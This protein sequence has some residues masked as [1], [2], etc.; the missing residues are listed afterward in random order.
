[1]S[2]EP[3]LTG[4]AGRIGTITLNRPARRNAVNTPMRDALHQQIRAMADNAEVSVILLRGAGRSF[5]AGYDL[6]SDDPEMV[7]LGNDALRWHDFQQRGLEFLLA[8]WGARKP[9]IAEVQGHAL[10]FGCA[11]AMVCDLVIAAEDAQFGEPEIRFQSI[12]SS[13]VLPWVIGAR[14]ARELLY[15][16]DIVDA[17]TARDYGM[18]NRVV[19]ASELPA[20]AAAYARRLA[21]IGPEALSRAKVAINRGIEA[22]GFRNG[23]QGSL[24][25]VSPLYTVET[26]MV[27]EFRKGVEKLGLRDAIKQRNAE[28]DEKPRT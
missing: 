17:R 26:E 10:G 22:G 15:M 4:I 2:D 6:S 8:I 25:I 18:V 20:A 14:R 3:V 5:C 1:M 7:A 24:D 13:V 11:L 16:G 28:F 21:R 12:S 23:L 19:A 27:R 9:V